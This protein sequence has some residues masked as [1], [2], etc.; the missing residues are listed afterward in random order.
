MDLISL[1]RDAPKT[2]LMADP[3]YGKTVLVDKK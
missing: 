3:L 1:D 2:P